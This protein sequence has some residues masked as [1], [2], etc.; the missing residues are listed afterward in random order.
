MFDFVWKVFYMSISMERD[1]FEKALMDFEMKVRKRLPSMINISLGGQGGREQEIS[2]KYFL[3]TLERQRKLL[4]REQSK[5]VRSS[6]RMR[7]LNTCYN[8]DSQLKSMNNRDVHQRHLKLRHHRL[9]VP[10]VYD[11][12][13]GP[14][15]GRLLN[16]T[17]DG[18]LLSTREQMH[19]DQELHL[20]VSGERGKAKTL[21]SMSTQEGQVETELRLV[22]ASPDLMDKL[23]KKV[24]NSSTE[25]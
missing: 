11:V 5:G 1:E 13:E 16:M 8:M 4:M 9:N 25:S 19:I 7:F 14:E 15:Q 17:D 18:V 21:W 6:Q 2:F 12:G 22:D 24:D 23:K 20:S 10:V 3:E